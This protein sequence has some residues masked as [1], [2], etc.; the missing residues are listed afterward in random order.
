MAAANT[1]RDIIPSIIDLISRHIHPMVFVEQKVGDDSYIFDLKT[2]RGD[3]GISV[4][5]IRI[6]VRP[7]YLEQRHGRRTRYS[8]PLA[9]P[10]S[11]IKITDLD[12]KPDYKG[13]GFG[14]L[15]LIYGLCK[16]FQIYPEIMN[17]ILD[18]C[19]V[20]IGHIKN[21]YSR[22]G[23]TF[24]DHT[25][26]ID[27]KYVVVPDDGFGCEKTAYLGHESYFK[28]L[29]RKT[30][31]I[32]HNRLLKKDAEQQEQQRTSSKGVTARMTKKSPKGPRPRP[33]GRMSHIL[34][35]GETRRG[36]GLS[37]KSR[38]TKARKSRKSRKRKQ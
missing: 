20:R 27:K 21:I 19:S 26:L 11:V 28:E 6:K 8:V 29:Y 37:R 14:S 4:G 25:E 36:G 12:V 24:D 35:R 5:N 1:D 23:F 2:A 3:S 7:H 34:T 33:Q 22:L 30:T 13:Q 32:I 9:E 38:K 17:A 18:D 10:E 15:I 16:I 31:N